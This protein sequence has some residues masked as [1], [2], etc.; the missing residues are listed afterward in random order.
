MAFTF[1]SF[2][3][4][5]FVY[6]SRNNEIV[7]HVLFAL[8]VESGR[9][10]IDDVSLRRRVGVIVVGLPTMIGERN[11]VT[12]VYDADISLPTNADNILYVRACVH[13]H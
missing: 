11:V 12:L 10:W 3:A 13:V 7:R 8:D 5:T 1:S 9:H 4:T 2:V 6:N